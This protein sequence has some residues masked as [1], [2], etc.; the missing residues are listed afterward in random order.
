MLGA[1]ARSRAEQQRLVQDAGHELRTPLTSLRTN[2]SVMRRHPDMAADDARADPRRSRR[3]GH[4]THRAGQRTGRG[5]V[6]RARSISRTSGST[7][8]SWPPRSPSGS[9][10]VGRATVAVTRRVRRSM[11]D[12]PRAGSTGRSPTSSTTPASSIR[13]AGPIDVVIEGGIA[14]RARPRAGHPAGR[15]AA[16]CSTGSTVPMRRARC[17]GR[18]SASPSSARSSSGSAD[19]C[20]R[21]T[22]TAAARPSGSVCR[23]PAVPVTTPDSAA[24]PVGV[25]LVALATEDDR[26]R[27]EPSL[28]EFVEQRRELIV[29]ARR[30]MMEQHEFAERRPGP[31][32]RSPAPASSD[33]TARRAACSAVTNWLSWMSRSASWARSSA[34]CLVG[35]SAAGRWS[36]M[37]TTVPSLVADPVAER[38]APL[39]RDRSRDDRQPLQLECMPSSMKSN[40]HEP[41]NPSGPI[42]K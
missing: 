27:S 26:E 23:L 30:C 16:R 11:V 37:Y 20:T 32:V 28:T 21:R 4:R 2:L 22:V 33:R 15:H 18:G 34:A 7:S 9:A 41:F 13:P 29:G 25:E 31:T 6:G 35:P 14:D 17:P 42:G 1:L 40:R 36:G 3:R 24:A 8:S 12:A 38:A 10:V 5:G 39:V 19:R